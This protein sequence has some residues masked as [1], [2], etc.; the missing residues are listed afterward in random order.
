[1]IGSNGDTGATWFSC[2]KFKGPNGGPVKVV[3]DA[4]DVFELIVHVVTFIV[5]DG[6]VQFLHF[7]INNPARTIAKNIQGRNGK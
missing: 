2:I 3:G 4:S 5:I 1:M 6:I 7:R